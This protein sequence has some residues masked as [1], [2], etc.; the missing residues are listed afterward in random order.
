MKERE[1][2]L[3]QKIKMNNGEVARENKGI[4]EQRSYFGLNVDNLSKYGEN[5][6][7]F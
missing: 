1:K 7:G 4:D 2:L 5:I 3:N 6:P